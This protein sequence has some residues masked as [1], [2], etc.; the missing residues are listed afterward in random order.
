MTLSEPTATKLVKDFYNAMRGFIVIDES[1]LP[2]YEEFLTEEKIDT[3]LLAG[4]LSGLQSLAEIVSEE[5]IHTIETSNSKFI[6]ELRSHYFYVLWI[7]KAL[8]DIAL[9]EPLIT[10]IISRFEGASQKDIDKQVIISNL[11]ETPDYE[12]IGQRLIKFNTGSSSGTYRKLLNDP[13]R[14][15]NPLKVAKELAGVNG[16]LI[17]S[18][19]GSIIHSEFPHEKPLFNLGPLTNFLVGLRQSIQNLD[20]GELEEITTQNYRFII[21]NGEDYFYVF[22][23]IKALMNEQQLMQTI[24]KIMGRYEGL[25]RKDAEKIEVLPNLSAIPEYELLGQLSLEMRG[26]QEKNQQTNTLHRQKGKLCFGDEERQWKKEKNQL[27]NFMD[28]FEEVFLAGVIQP[29]KRFFVIKRVYDIN[30]WMNSANALQFTDLQARV[31]KLAKTNVLRL[32]Q[33]GKEFRIMAVSEKQLLFV[34]LNEENLAADRY[35]LR[36]QKI[37]K[38]L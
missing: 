12:K 32:S 38:N 1:G 16:L 33:N 7:E 28:I 23:V 20:P 13:Q 5:R 22:E 34:V 30:D 15:F 27:A 25:R 17:I 10:K 21:K 19:E 6:F 35:L 31:E 4:L 11:T 14:D 18:E 37:L 2:K 3:I 9:Y 8:S 26:L 29:D 36:L 24:R